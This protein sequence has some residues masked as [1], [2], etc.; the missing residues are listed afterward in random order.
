MP[1]NQ[2]AIVFILYRHKKDRFKLTAKDIHRIADTLAK[3]TAPTEPGISIENRIPILH[4]NRIQCSL[5]LRHQVS[6]PDAP[7]DIYRNLRPIHYLPMDL[8]PTTITP[9]EYRMF[10][11][12]L[13]LREDGDIP[14]GAIPTQLRNYIRMKDKEHQNRNVFYVTSA[15][16]EAMSKMESNRRRIILRV[17][18]LIGSPTGH[19]LS[20]CIPQKPLE[21]PRCLKITPT[22]WTIPTPAMKTFPATRAIVKSIAE[23]KLR[24]PAFVGAPPKCL[25][26]CFTHATN[27]LLS[28]PVHV[29]YQCAI[30]VIERVRSSSAPPSS[31][32]HLTD[33][34][35]NIA[36]NRSP[37]L[38]FVESPPE[39]NHPWGSISDH[40]LIGRTLKEPFSEDT[41]RKV[42]AL[43]PTLRPKSVDLRFFVSLPIDPSNHTM[44][45][46]LQDCEEWSLE[47]VRE[48]TSQPEPSMAPPNQLPAIPMERGPSRIL[49]DLLQHDPPRRE[50][51][52]KKRAVKPPPAATRNQQTPGGKASQT[53]ETPAAEMNYT[54]NLTQWLQDTPPD[55]FPHWLFVTAIRK[56]LRRA[57]PNYP[58]L[59][60]W[61]EE[62]GTSSPA[63]MNT[64][65]SALNALYTFKRIFANNRVYPEIDKPDP[66]HNLLRVMMGEPE[67]GSSDW[68]DVADEIL[69]TPTDKQ[70]MDSISQRLRI[71]ANVTRTCCIRSSNY[72]KGEAI[73]SD[74]SAF[75]ETLPMN[76]FVEAPNPDDVLQHLKSIKPPRTRHQEDEMVKLTRWSGANALLLMKARRHTARPNLSAL[77]TAPDGNCLFH[78]VNAAQYLLHPHTFTKTLN[79]E[80]LRSLA[81]Y[82]AKVFVVNNEDYDQ[83][84]KDSTIK[85]IDR[86]IMDGCDFI[87]EHVMSALASARNGDIVVIKEIG[88]P[89]RYS[90][91]AEM[92]TFLKVPTET[93]KAE[94]IILLHRT[95]TASHFDVA[96]ERPANASPTKITQQP[97]PPREHTPTHKRR[98]EHSPSPTTGTNSTESI[99]DEDPNGEDTANQND[100]LNP[101]ADE[102]PQS[103]S[104]PLPPILRGPVPRMHPPQSPSH[105]EATQTFPPY[106]PPLPPGPPPRK[107]QPWPSPRPEASPHSS[108]TGK[109][110]PDPFA[111]TRPSIRTN[112]LQRGPP[113]STQQLTPRESPTSPP[114]LPPIHGHIPKS[115]S[116]PPSGEQTS[117]MPRLPSIYANVSESGPRVMAEELT[118]GACKPPIA[119]S[120]PGDWPS[121]GYP[122]FTQHPSPN[123]SPPP[124]T[125]PPIHR[126]GSP[127]T[128]S[129]PY[130]GDQP[131]RMPSP[132]PI[133]VRPVEAYGFE[134]QVDTTAAE[135]KPTPPPAATQLPPIPLP[136]DAE[137]MS[138]SQLKRWIKH[139]RKVPPETAAIPTSPHQPNSDSNISRPL[140]T[141]TW[142]G[143]T[144]TQ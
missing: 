28:S 113:G 73:L 86:S 120:T 92:L 125:L 53:P 39:T 26:K 61:L 130:P 52:R 1:L 90:P 95:S 126:C 16:I 68:Q 10:D 21:C 4:W 9:E 131:A 135:E 5:A 144:P 142:E 83:D 97:T 89:H 45:L 56:G 101:T 136:P 81:C 40:K 36:Q 25:D 128:R 50:T 20:G 112:V 134:S 85:D 48:L 115:R 77:Y 108:E 72:A 17:M 2:N 14:D 80:D 94:T 55:S 49:P 102:P 82:L 107:A 114:V 30:P 23:N 109:T 71:I 58:D 11:P 143:L 76:S 141:K 93:P 42:I 103:A 65:T 84:L 43:A 38:G 22:L 75:N 57:D 98:Q 18:S 96:Y 64:L 139:Q 27:R 123:R 31:I 59:C 121:Q 60:E 51:Q 32:N 79:H 78:S 67:V 88:E 129:T 19:L 15:L 124:P 54:E 47:A 138:K 132:P 119:P 63:E 122:G 13:S 12:L 87:S 62:L 3:V 110:A 117:P 111:P 140:S 44:A 74:R 29:C 8:P 100:P 24:E 41:E 37:T 35:K 46:T 6:T 105:A 34:L 116:P 66:N 33:D 104:P 127:S 70:S 106:R 7:M 133:H 69:H 99:G 91:I 137:S 118:P